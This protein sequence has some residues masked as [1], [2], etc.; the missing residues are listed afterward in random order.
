MRSSSP[1]PGLD[2]I[3]KEAQDVLPC[4][5]RTPHLNVHGLVIFTSPKS[6][7]GVYATRPI[8]AG[9]TVEISPILLFPGEEYEKHGQHTQLDSY[10][11]VWSKRSGGQSDMALALGMGSLFNHHPN[12][13]VSWRRDQES[14]T[15]AFTTARSIRS[16][17]ELCIS[18]GV[19]RMWW[20]PEPALPLRAPSPPPTDDDELVALAGMGDDAPSD[21]DGADGTPE[22]AH[23]SPSALQRSTT[24]VQAQDETPDLPKS[25]RLW[26]LTAA[27]DPATMAVPLARGWVVNVPA[28]MNG[29]ATSFARNV[30]HALGAP[31]RASGWEETKHLKMV[32]PAEEK[33]TLQILLCLHRPGAE[34]HQIRRQL[35]LH[36]PWFDASEHA[37]RSV[38][39]PACPA[40][41]KTRLQ[42]WND[43]WPSSIRPGTQGSWLDRRSEEELWSSSER[44]T[45]VKEG[46]QCAIQASAQAKARGQIPVG[47]YVCPAFSCVGACGP[48]VRLSAHDTRISEHHPLRHA[49][50]NVVRRVADARKASS[51]S[52]NGTP[53]ARTKPSCVSQNLVEHMQGQ[54]EENSRCEHY[55]NAP[56]V[57]STAR[58]PTVSPAP[59]S[60]GTDYLLTNLALF[61]THEPCTFCAMALVHSRVKQVFFLIPSP[62]SG[63]MSG[64]EEPRENRPACGQSGGPYAIHEKA[65]L[66]HHFEVYQG[67]M[68]GTMSGW[69]QAVSLTGIDP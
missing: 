61:T 57:E 39:V 26:R 69:E 10:T 56:S 36:A 16:G 62:H 8:A 34:E 54:L 37:L 14:L 51:S 63:G 15:I 21:D 64:A 2:P 22:R 1:S 49:V 12:P 43:I 68:D 20:E 17:E 19:G 47:V 28:R 53:T 44:S 23:Q 42:E 66:N 9:T 45:W 33:G 29:E 38:P 24:A 59:A 11:F 46:F 18:Y 67:I 32:R 3:P 41:N 4:L 40:P 31:S 65:S 52:T 6:G 50:L 35:S 48:P 13:N 5:P 60:N 27:I 7:R 30:G 58:P 25:L 55:H